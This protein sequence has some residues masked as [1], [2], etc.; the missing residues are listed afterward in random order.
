[1]CIHLMSFISPLDR[2]LAVVFPMHMPVR[3]ME[4]LRMRGI[5]IVEVP[6]EEFDSQGANVLALGTARRAGCRR[7]PRDPPPDGGR[8]RRGPHVLGRRDL[9]QG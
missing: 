7:Q 4:I 8:G 5:A 1:M 2:D 3:L 6:E 9:G